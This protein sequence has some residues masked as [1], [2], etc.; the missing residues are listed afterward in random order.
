M[1]PSH[2]LGP[3]LSVGVEQRISS[4]LLI[5]KFPAMKHVSNDTPR[6]TF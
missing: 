5:L 2:H 1:Q 6:L 4:D 3:V